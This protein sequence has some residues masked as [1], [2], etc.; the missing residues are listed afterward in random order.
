[1]RE[2]ATFKINSQKGRILQKMLEDRRRWFLAAD[3]CG[4]KK[5]CPFVGYKAPTRMCEMQV[6]GLLI[7]RWA[8]IKTALGKKLKEYKIRPNT[9]AS[10]RGSKVILF[11]F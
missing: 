8:N 1:M 4:R 6:E 7:S 11:D 9:P 5:D 10:I 3:F 2:E